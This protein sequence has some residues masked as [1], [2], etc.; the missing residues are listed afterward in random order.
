M[1]HYLAALSHAACALRMIAYK[2][3]RALISFTGY[4]YSERN[5]L[6]DNINSLRLYV[7]SIKIKL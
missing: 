6:T 5:R 1:A 7:I 3:T 2:K 4:F